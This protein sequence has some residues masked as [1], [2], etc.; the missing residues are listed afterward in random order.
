MNSSLMTRAV[1]LEINL[2]NLKHNIKEL[3]KHIKKDV[4]LMATV[5]G[6]AYGHGAITVS[7][8][9]LENGV[10]RLAV[11][12]LL[13]G[14]ELRM[15][16]IEASILIM[17]YTPPIQYDK[18]IEYNLIQN[19]Y[20]LED[21]KLLSQEAGNANKTVKIHIKIDT[22]MGRL[23]FVPNE[24]AIEEISHIYNLPNIKVEGIYTHFAKSDEDDKTFTKN[25]YDKF[26]WLIEKL[27]EKN[28]NIPIKHVSNSA[29]I[30]RM[31]EYNLDM[32]RAGI[33][34][35]GHYPSENLK[36]E[37]IDI[38]PAMALKTSISYIKSLPKGTG[39]SYNQTFI[40]GRDSIIATL[41]IG[42]ADGYS[43]T[44]S[45][46]GEVFVGGSLAPIV[47]NICMDQMMIDITDIKNINKDSEV[48]LFD[49][50][51]GII[52]I[53]DLAGKLGTI[54]YEVMSTMGRRLPR[55]YIEN[56]NIK[57]IVDYLLDS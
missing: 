11:S 2:D 31:P 20:D 1:K 22:G 29:A 56:G 9:F 24:K 43:R 23:G 19:I 42:Y 13:E 55:V 49:Y 35:Y 39:I 53:E 40:A 41:P 38:R 50:R 25:Q 57:H 6:N 5:K 47:G 48:I 26:L 54:N 8:V 36:K 16:G 18:I 15:S 44:L 34:L 27:E 37:N 45:N 21:A 32:V 28:I 10:D 3:K 51:D 30:I 12:T 7:K 17:N 46:K 4:L 14:M 33:I 52:S